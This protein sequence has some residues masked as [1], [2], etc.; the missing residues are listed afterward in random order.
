MYRRKDF[1]R[2]ER[3]T[4][5]EKIRKEKD[6]ISIREDQSEFLKSYKMIIKIYRRNLKRE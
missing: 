6:F 3:N 4:I 2:K 5:G 1:L